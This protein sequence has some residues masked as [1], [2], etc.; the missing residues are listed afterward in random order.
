M[1][2]ETAYLFPNFSN[3][4]FLFSNTKG[5]EFD[6]AQ[7]EAAV[8]EWRTTVL[9]DGKGF[10]RIIHQ[11]SVCL[12]GL[13]EINWKK[14][15]I[16]GYFAKGSQALL[17]GRY[18]SADSPYRGHLRSLALVGELFPTVEPNHTKPLRTASFITTF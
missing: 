2:R 10:R 13:W 16:R 5:R 9:P 4:K 1:D 7:F 6:Q 3:S 8:A 15:N 17:V 11:N 18:S 14:L 12:T